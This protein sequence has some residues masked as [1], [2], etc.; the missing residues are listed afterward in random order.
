MSADT[1]RFPVGNTFP[2]SSSGSTGWFAGMNSLASSLLNIPAAQVSD[3]RSECD[4]GLVD[5]AQN[6]SGGTLTFPTSPRGGIAFLQSLAVASKF[7]GFIGVSN[8]VLGNIKTDKWL[9]ACRAKISAGDAQSTHEMGVATGVGG[10][11]TVSGVNA[12]VGFIV[13]NGVASLQANNGGALT[14]QATTWPVDT[15]TSHNFVVTNDGTTI[16][17]Y[18]DGV[19]VGT[20]VN[21][22]V[23][24]SV[25]GHFMC[26]VSNGTTAA[27]RTLAADKVGVWFDQAA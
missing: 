23:P 9:Y 12:G 8:G 19:L 22:N 17:A 6:V 7:A 3:T 20:I 16:N 2:S 21:T 25:G 10:I 18:V 27:N 5:I 13:I 4:H 11:G 26:F 15:T 1:A 14:T 24:T